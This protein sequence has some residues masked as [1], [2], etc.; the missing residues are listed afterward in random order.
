M[1]SV[2]PVSFTTC[3]N[4]QLQSIKHKVNDLVHKQNSLLATTP[5]PTLPD[6]WC[7]VYRPYPQSTWLKS[8]L[9]VHGSILTTPKVVPRC[10]VKATTGQCR[11]KWLGAACLVAIHSSLVIRVTE[12]RSDQ[13][14]ALNFVWMIEY[15]K[16]FDPLFRDSVQHYRSACAW[17][18]RL[19]STVETHGVSHYAVQH[20]NAGVLYGLA[21]KY[22]ITRLRLVQ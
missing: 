11:R 5:D 6:L 17:N 20:T 8:A 21:N 13:L 7:A 22:I 19:N 14:C 2:Q 4:I 16:K 18:D 9:A 12:S 10:L 3:M 1:F 15:R